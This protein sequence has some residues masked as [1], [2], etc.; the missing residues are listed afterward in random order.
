MEKE[1]INGELEKVAEEDQAKANKS[2]V[3]RNNFVWFNI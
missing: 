3:Y 1:Q 2:I